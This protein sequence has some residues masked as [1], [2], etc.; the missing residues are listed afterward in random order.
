MASNP[1]RRGDDTPT[2]VT[3]AFPQ[4][5]PPQARGRLGAPRGVGP[6]RGATPAGAG[7]TASAKAGSGDI[8]SN[9]RRRGDD[10]VAVPGGGRYPEQPPQARGRQHPEPRLPRHRRATPAGAGTTVQRAM[11]D[12]PT[13]SNPRRRGDDG[14]SGPESTK[15]TE[16]PPQARGR[17]QAHRTESPHAGATPAGAGT[18]TLV[19]ATFPVSPSNPRRRGDDGRVRT[20]RAA[21]VEQPPQARGRQRETTAQRV[22]GGATPAGAG[23]TCP[24]DATPAAPGSNPRRRGDDATMGKSSTSSGEQ[25]PQAR[26]RLGAAGSVDESS[27]AT[28][29]GAGTTSPTPTAAKAARSNPRRRGDDT[30]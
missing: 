20:G 17:P 6:T 16:Q 10:P 5:Q 14:R 23:T 24:A 13:P 28:P 4:E 30:S 8:W 19:N 11:S 29:A 18:T 7:T 12:G 3:V 15:N 2:P 22:S 1:R 27:G 21:E 26:G 25:P 9:P